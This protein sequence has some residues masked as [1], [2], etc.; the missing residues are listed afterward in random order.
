MNPLVSIIVPVYNA[1]DFLP[2]CIHSICCQT[3]TD[4]EL[5]LIDDG[6]K[7]TSGALCD[8]Y[9]AQDA[10]IRVLHIEN[11]GQAKARNL[12][13]TLANGEYLL[14]V[15]ADDFLAGDTV[16]ETFIDTARR[17]GCD[18]TVG[19]YARFWKGRSL[20][21]ASAAE[22][23]AFD[24]ESAEFRF[25]GFYSGGSLSYVWGKLYR[26]AFLENHALRLPLLNYAEDKVFSLHCYFC[27]AQ[28][29]FTGKIEYQYRMNPA[30]I[31]Y[32]YRPDSCTQWL[33]AARQME[34]DLQAA[35]GAAAWRDVVWYTIVFAAFFDAKMEYIQHNHAL[36][37]VRTLLVNYNADPLAQQ[38]FSA[39]T[40]G[41]G[42]CEIE[43]RLWSCMLRGFSA[44]M[45]LHAYGA[46]CLGIKLLA[47]LRIDERLS[48]TGLRE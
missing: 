28:Y 12:G 20:P 3:C 29:A 18:I 21:A 48:D 26:R 40:R 6:S 46:L 25:R 32:R 41:E 31:S 30:S 10:R 14:F 5:F 27:G 16:L 42:V 43:Q 33:A 37:P 11:G 35:G 22:L 19:D 34:A 24:R 15:D 2:D 45:R 9:A 23:T 7:D 44:A 38:A 39:V 47:D 36:H 17:T 8:E 13:L 1:A 4:W